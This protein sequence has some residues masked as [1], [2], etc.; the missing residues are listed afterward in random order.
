LRVSI[1]GCP[2][3]C[4]QHQIADVGL[5]GG[6]VTIDGVWM[7]G[8]QVWLGGDLAKD[9]MGRVVGRVAEADVVS[10]TEAIVGVWEALRERGETLSDTVNRI[11]VAGF[12]AQIGAVFRGRW[13]PG[14][15]PEEAGLDDRDPRYT[16]RLP[17]VGVMS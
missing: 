7:L 12:D 15:E 14:P 13:A 17:L 4:A 11:G 1:S 6:K 10:I 2:N 16:R 5:S 9:R 3:A 8:Y